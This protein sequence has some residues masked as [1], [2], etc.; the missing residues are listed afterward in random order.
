MVLKYSD[1][2]QLHGGQSGSNW[3]GR[4]PADAQPIATAPERS[5]QPILVY[6]ANG[7]GHWALHH[8]GAWRKLAPYKDWRTGDV[9]WRMDGTAISQAVAW[10]PKR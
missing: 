7:T 6:E 1:K 4:F 2:P 10:L 8:G 3:R 9:Q 5:A